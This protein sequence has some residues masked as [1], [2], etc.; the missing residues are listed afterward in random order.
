LSALKTFLFKFSQAH[1]VFSLRKADT[2]W[3]SVFVLTL[4]LPLEF[5]CRG[6]FYFDLIN[7]KGAENKFGLLI[8]KTSALHKKYEKYQ[9]I[10]GSCSPDLLGNITY[11]MFCGLKVVTSRK[12]VLIWKYFEE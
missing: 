10:H 8:P 2:G 5:R 12:L 7:S 6:F 9:F 11:N 1:R 4:S 3:I